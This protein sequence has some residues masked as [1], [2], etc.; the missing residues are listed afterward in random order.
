M[1]DINT[2]PLTNLKSSWEQNLEGDLSDEQWEAVLDLVH[3]SPICARHALIQFKMLHRTKY[4]NARLATF[5]P[6][7]S[8]SCTRC[9]QTPA[10]LIH[11]FWSCPALTSY[12]TDISNTFKEVFPL[13]A[14][15]GLLPTMGIPTDIRTVVAFSSLLARRL[16]LLKW[17]VSPL[18]H[19][20]W[21]KGV[22]RALKL[23]RIRFS[24]KGSLAL[25]KTWRPFISHIQT[26]VLVEE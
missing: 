17:H 8:P 5:P 12:W 19:N 21:I 18:T 22:H 15:F 6:A 2:S 16:I 7:L 10:D 11:M 3:S 4:T 25:E 26:L 1:I 9:K 24:M 20:S 13:T 23:E 14:V